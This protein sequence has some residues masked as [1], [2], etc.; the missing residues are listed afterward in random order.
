[1]FLYQRHIYQTITAI[2][3]ETFSKTVEEREYQTLLLY[4]FCKF[5]GV[6]SLGKV[7]PERLAGAGAVSSKSAEKLLRAG[8][9]A[10]PP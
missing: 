2:M 9:L 6:G 4:N 8:V 5:V 10:A 3:E 1:M 7:T